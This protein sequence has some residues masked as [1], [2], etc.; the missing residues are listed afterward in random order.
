M[1]RDGG[2]T[3]REL[4]RRRSP[5][6]LG[7]DRARVNVTRRRHAA[8]SLEP[9][10]TLRWR[11]RVCR[12]QC[13]SEPRRARRRPEVLRARSGRGTRGTSRPR[14]PARPGSAMPA[15]SST[16]SAPRIGS[17]VRSAS[18]IASDGRALT[19]IP[20]SK[21]RSAKKTPSRQLGDPDRSSGASERRRGRRAAGRGSAVAAAR[22][23][24]GRRRWRSPRPHRSRSAGSAPRRPR[25][26]ARSAGWTAS[27][28]GLRRRPAGARHHPSHDSDPGATP[29]SRRR[30]GVDGG[31]RRSSAASPPSPARRAAAPTAPRA[32]GPPRRPAACRLGVALAQ[33][34]GDDLLDEADL[35][36]G[37]DL[38]R[39]Q[40]SGL[41]AE[42]GH[43]GDGAG[44]DERRRRRSAGRPALAIRP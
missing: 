42:R 4:H 17:P 41:D 29:A 16:A 21:T 1:P 39:A 11:S 37:G 13:G 2:T 7:P 44:D 5:R 24:A 9:A 22:R 40:V 15:S 35:A 3:P 23:P 12:R 36:V 26:A 6:T 8:A 30:I 28:P 34:R 31:Q 33:Q 32:R 10:A 27:R 43:L 18:A 19:S 14:P 20:P 38:E 25:A